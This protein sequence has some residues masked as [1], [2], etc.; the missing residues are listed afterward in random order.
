MVAGELR[1]YSG[2]ESYCTIEGE[3]MWLF[4]EGETSS[5]MYI[6]CIADILLFCSVV[7]FLLKHRGCMRG[8]LWH[9]ARS[10]R[11]CLL[12]PS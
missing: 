12:L 3:R 4:E 8:D 7:S 5:Y 6:I 10:R 9:F 11:F 1:S 2:L